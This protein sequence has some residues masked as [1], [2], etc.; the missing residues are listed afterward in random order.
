M[1]NILRRL[2][3]IVLLSALPGGVMAAEHAADHLDLTGHWVG[4]LSIGL[5]VLA[6]LFVG[7]SR[8]RGEKS[9]A[10]G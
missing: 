2:S 7:R 8:Y 6:Y 1:Q 4:W 3:P 9:H 5:F 10:C